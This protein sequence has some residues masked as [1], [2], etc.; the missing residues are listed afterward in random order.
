MGF[1]FK[2]S[3]CSSAK[4]VHRCTA[5][6]LLSPEAANFPAASDLHLVVNTSGEFSI[7]AY[8]TQQLGYI[9]HGDKEDAMQLAAFYGHYVC[10]LLT[11]AVQ[12]KG[13][14]EKAGIAALQV[15]SA[16][17]AHNSHN[18]HH[19]GKTDICQCLSS[20]DNQPNFVAAWLLTG[21]PDTP[22]KLAGP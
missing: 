1:V 18:Q 10:V 20:S 7:M 9:V 21:Y 22:A 16:E 12:L 5:T 6:K 14:S 4:Q 3:N 15:L 2:R 8:T 11:A 17:Y 13:T 19:S